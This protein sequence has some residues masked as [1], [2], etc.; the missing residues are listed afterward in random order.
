MGLL[1]V[2]SNIAFEKLTISCVDAKS[3]YMTNGHVDNKITF[4]VQQ[5]PHVTY[6]Q[7]TK[8][9]NL[10]DTPLDYTGESGKIARVNELEEGLEFTKI[11]LTDITQYQEDIEI[12]SSQIIDFEELRKYEHDQGTPNS[13]WTINHD[14]NKRPSVSI[15]DS[16]GSNVFGQVEYNDENNLTITFNTA[17]SGVAYLN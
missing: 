9:T 2:N 16:A 10:T 8:F 6:E 3:V 7:P 17:F 5:Y 12:S 15:I 13:V 4:S 14:L 11:L 1:A